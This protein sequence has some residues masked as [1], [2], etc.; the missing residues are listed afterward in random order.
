MDA[1]NLHCGL[2]GLLVDNPVITC[3]HIIKH[4]L[5]S[6][7]NQMRI[8]SLAW[9]THGPSPSHF[10]RDEPQH[11]FQSPKLE[12]TGNWRQFMLNAVYITQY[13]CLL[14]ERLCFLSVNDTESHYTYSNILLNII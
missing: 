2:G 12:K 13:F 4:Q 14:L 10:H 6:N 1:T 9:L 8:Y 7:C 3:A 5:A 11:I